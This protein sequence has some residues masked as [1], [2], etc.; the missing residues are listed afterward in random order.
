MH[1]R[2]RLRR[3]G[4]T[5]LVTVWMVWLGSVAN[6]A[7]E[8]KTWVGVI[9]NSW[10]NGANWSPAGVPTA[11]DDAVIATGIPLISTADAAVG[12]V[13]V[14]SGLTVNGRTLTVGATAP[15]TIAAAVDLTSGNLRLNGTTTWSAGTIQVQDAGTVENAGVLEVS[16]SVGVTAFGPGRTLLRTLFGGVTQVSGALSVGSELEND[17]ILR[18]LDG[19]VVTQADFVASP[20]DSGGV[21]DAQGSGVLSLSNVLMGAASS[22]TGSGTIR[23]AGGTSRV[24]PG[25]GYAAGITEVNGGTLDFDDDGSTGAL[26]MA[27]EGMRRGD[28]TLTV[29]GGESSLG[30]SNFADGGVTAFSIDSRTT[31]TD[32]VDFFAAGHTL[33]LDG[34]TTWSA[35]LVQIQDAGTVEN[36]GVLEVTGSVGVT[37]FGPG[38]KLFRTLLGGVTRVSGALSVGSELENDGILRA[39]DGGVL[40]QA[41]FVAS[42][43]DSGGTFDAQGTGVLSLS[44]VLMGAASSA[45]GTGTIR[46]AGGTSRVAPGAS[47]AAGITDVERWHPRL[48]R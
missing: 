24:A 34:T 5:T 12:S 39:L 2:S 26:R 13:A 31:I 1:G 29:G 30:L 38:R 14:S 40:T 9:D 41:N 21:F 20:A 28:G 22:A 46:F 10:H 35:G 16:G 27:G 15:S 7:A 3:A 18:A 23:F 47:Y 11:A 4:W 19:G 48:R 43:A 17:G 8:T 45:T 44:N 37:A 33:R 32:F 42:P 25:A 36:A 6:A